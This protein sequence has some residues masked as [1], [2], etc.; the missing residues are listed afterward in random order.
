MKPSFLFILLSC[1]VQLVWAQKKPNVIF[2]LTDDLGYGDIGVF[3]QNQRKLE[4]IRSNP[5]TQT[6]NIDRLA[7]NGAMLMQHYTAAPVCAPSRASLFL[8]QNQGHANV[9][10]NQ[11]DKALQNNY[12]MQGVLKSLGYSTALF[13][14]WGLQG[15][16][17]DTASWIAHPL[18]RGFDYFYGY[19]RHTDG[20]EHYPKEGLYRGKKEV[21]NNYTEVSSDLDKCYTGD[22]WTASAKNWI[23]N[24]EQKDP[25]QPFF[26]FIS[27]DTP[28]AVMELPTQAYPSGG[29]LKGGVQWVGKPG[30][31]IN[32]ASGTIDSYRYPEYKNATYDHDKNPTTPEIAWPDTYMRYASSIRRIDDGIGDLMQLLK[33]L[34]I[35]E[36]TIVIFSS[37]NGPSIES[38]LP[39][40]YA[41]NEANFFDSFGPFAGIKRDCLEGGLRMPA[42]ATWKGHIA[43]GQKIQSP[44]AAYDWLPTFVEAA[45]KR[46][47]ASVNGVS[48]L[49]LLTGKEKTNQS[50][51]YVE[52]FVNGNSPNYEEFSPE[53]RSKKRNQMQLI[54]I[55]DYAGIRYNVTKQ[56]DDFEFYDITKDPGQTKNLAPTLAKLQSKMKEKT[57]Q[58]RRVD[59]DAIRPYDNEFISA[60][61]GIQVK[62]QINWQFTTETVSWLHDSYSPIKKADNFT[63][64]NVG[65]ASGII[66]I[67]GYIKIPKDDVYTFY[68]NKGIKAF[69]KIHD[70]GVIDADFNNG[71]TA[72]GKLKLKAGLHP[73]KLY[74]ANSSEKPLLKWSS[75]EIK[76]QEIPAQQLFTK[77]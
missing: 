76:I 23:V 20:H 66:C 34:K 22:L 31:M 29:G 25:N 9:R 24:H 3:Y 65:K 55:G 2:I 26:A 8:G 13:G 43:A 53:H 48:L 35:E 77:N 33:D 21:W 70:I 63:S 58:L 10:D 37:D 67:D 44:N 38:Y 51:I 61:N 64:I 17:K 59:S 4:D 27:Y 39:K 71:K 28:H 73:F 36:N 1:A 6:P 62:P 72:Q 18:K 69:L 42:I 75:D 54:R 57:L 68:T 60:I 19:M 56:D 50:Q 16:G 46:A 52:Y 30:Q 40:G 47:P 7:N 49:P 41:P 15:D 12:T 11:F 74:Y 5:Y 14:K 45:G 32:T